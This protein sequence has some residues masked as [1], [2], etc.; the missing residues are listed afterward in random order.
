MSVVFQIEYK[1]N[2]FW[3]KKCYSV[4]LKKN[5][6]TVTLALYSK[7][8]RTVTLALY[9]KNEQTITLALFSFPNRG[10]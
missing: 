6:R 10:L 8:E 4:V 5:E 2:L 7:N 3:T 9:L 1:V